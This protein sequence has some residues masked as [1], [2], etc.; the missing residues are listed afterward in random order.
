MLAAH[1]GLTQMILLSVEIRSQ[2][3]PNQ[4]WGGTFPE[5]VGAGEVG[6]GDMAL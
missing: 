6:P 1:L 3:D 5:G 4:V 2:S